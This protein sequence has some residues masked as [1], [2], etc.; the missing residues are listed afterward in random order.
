[1]IKFY[2]VTKEYIK[3]ITEIDQKLLINNSEF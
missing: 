1:M 3:N 2:A